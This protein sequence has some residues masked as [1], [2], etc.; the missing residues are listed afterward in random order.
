MKSFK[1]IFWVVLLFI[2]AAAAYAWIFVWN[3]PATNVLTS[4]AI[5]IP[6]N[7]L[8]DAYLKNEQEANTLYLEKILE[9]TG[10]IMNVSVNAEGSTV[11]LLKTK[12]S[13]FGVN[14]TLEQK[15]IVMKE[16]E[17]VTLKGICTGYLTDVVL[18]R[19]YKM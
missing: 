5:K 9:V 14:C 8:F 4:T 19:C 15:A 11:V 1:T 3:K 7:D 16:G 6:A 12:D 10:E 13:M 17:Q 18:I 2:I